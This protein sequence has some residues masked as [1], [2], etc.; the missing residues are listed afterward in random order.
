MIRIL[1]SLHQPLAILD[2]YLNDEI[3]E[4]INGAYTFKFSIYMDDE[5]SQY[6]ATG[7]IAEVEGQYFNIISPGGH[8]QVA[9]R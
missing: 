5:K 8:D 9:A 7:N 4:Q 6:I 3:S 1:N 2:D